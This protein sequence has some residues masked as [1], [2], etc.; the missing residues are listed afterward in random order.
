MIA[1]T[2]KFVLYVVIST[3]YGPHH[4][5]SVE[6]RAEFPTYEACRTERD[7][8]HRFATSEG[9]TV[10]AECSTQAIAR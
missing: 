8:T 6:T 1:A 5:N 10:Q 4:T 9:V 3:S 2:A 7:N